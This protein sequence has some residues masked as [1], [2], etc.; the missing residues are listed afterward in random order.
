M[1]ESTKAGDGGPW[2]FWA[3][4]LRECQES[5]LSYA[6]YCRRHDLTESAFGYWRKKLLAVQQDRF[7]FVELKVSAGKRSGIEVVLRN[8]IRLG[9]E[10]DFDE[11]VLKR[12]IG[13][14]EAL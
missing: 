14:L 2:E 6:A 12:V 8:Q 4:H 10:A 1:E 7:G 9:I 11:A 13:V 5:G 3:R